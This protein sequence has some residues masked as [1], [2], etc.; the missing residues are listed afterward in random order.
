MR[1]LFLGVYAKKKNCD[2]K[3]SL[4]LSF[5]LDKFEQFHF[6]SDDGGLCSPEDQEGRPNPGSL[7]VIYT[8]RYWRRQ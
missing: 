5:C 7:S 3:S 6:F 8:L 4:N 2:P 1:D